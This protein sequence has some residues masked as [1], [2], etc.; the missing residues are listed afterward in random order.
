MEE[1][2]QGAEKAFGENRKSIEEGLSMIANSSQDNEMRN[3]PENRKIPNL[4]RD[5]DMLSGKINLKISHEINRL[6]NGMIS[7]IEKAIS[8]AMS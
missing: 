2:N 7:Q 1:L 8:S 4:S 5:L 6:L 3:M